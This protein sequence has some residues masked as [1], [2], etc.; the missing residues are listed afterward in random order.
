MNNKIDAVMFDLGNVL[1]N[2]DHRIAAERICRFTDKGRDE[3]FNL[4]FDSGLTGLFEEGKVSPSEFFLKVKEALNL[5]LDYAEFVPIWNEIFFFSEKNLSVYNLA[6]S[7][8]NRYKVMLISNINILHFEYVKRTFPI[9]DA[10]HNIITSFEAGLRKPHP[11]IYRKAL[12]VLGCLAQN[13]FYTDDRPELIAGA[14]QLGIRS[15]VFNNPQELRENL[16][17][18]GVKCLDP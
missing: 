1:L 17:E 16:S 2:F 12:E 14:R 9:L 7:L 6:G 8:K 5:R 4:F 11:S 13:V 18:S 10:F 15:F 3:I